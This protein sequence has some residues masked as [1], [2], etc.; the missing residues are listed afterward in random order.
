MSYEGNLNIVFLNFPYDTTVPNTCIH[1]VKWHC[2]T[3]CG[4][5]G[6]VWGIVYLINEYVMYTKLFQSGCI[7]LYALTIC[8]RKKKTFFEMPEA[9]DP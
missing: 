9:I 3:A 1:L 6:V 5:V 8:V 7:K 2:Q 4:E